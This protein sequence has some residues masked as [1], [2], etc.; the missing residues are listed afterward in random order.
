MFGKMRNW[1]WGWVGLYRRG[2]ITAEIAGMGG[3]GYAGPLGGVVVYGKAN[4]TA[5]EF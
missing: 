4:K 3:D 2:S 5:G 1:G